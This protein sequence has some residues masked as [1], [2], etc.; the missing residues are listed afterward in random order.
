MTGF[1]RKFVDCYAKKAAPLTRYLKDDMAEPFDL[2]DEATAA[3]RALKMAI[4]SAP[5]LALPKA[6]G[7]FVLETDASA[8]QL[9][10]QLLQQQEDSSW[11]PIGFWS[12]Q[13][14]KAECNYSPTE[15][16]ALAIFWGIKMCRPY[17]ERTR[18]VVRSDHQALR[19]L[20]STST[21]D[22]NARILRWKLALSAYD[23]SV[24]YKPG[25]TN[26][27]ADELSRMVTD[28]LSPMLDPAEEDESIPC[29]VVDVEPGEV[30]LPPPPSVPLESPLL[31]VPKS[32]KA[33]SRNELYRAQRGDP[34]CQS[35]AASLTNEYSLLKPPGLF[36]DDDG[37]LCCS[38][39][40]PDM[41]Y[42]WVAP[43][44]L[45]E[46]ICKL[47]HFT[48]VAGHPGSTRMTANIA[49]TWYWPQLAKD[50]LAMVRRCPSCSAL[51]L[52]R[53]P[54]RTYPLTIFPPDRPLEFIAI[55]VLGPL[56]RTSRGNQYV[57][58]ICDRFS[59]MSIAVA[60][61]DQT[62]STVARALVD[63]WIA[64]FG[65]PITL[66]SDNGPCFASKFFQVLTKVLGVKHVFTSAYRPTTNGQVERW[67]ATLV[68]TLTNF[69]REKDWDLSLGLACVSYNSSVHAT[70]GYAPLE[71]STTREPAPS[72]WS[73]QPSLLPRGR[74]EKLQ[75][76]QALLA[77]AARLCES[78]K[79]T[80]HLRLERYKYLYDYH[81][82]RRHADLQVGDSVFVK[83]FMLEPGRSPKLSAPV[84]GPYPVVGIDGPNVV[85]RTRE[86]S[87]RLHLD[88]VMRC[89]TDLPSGVEWTPRKEVPTTSRRP[90]KD[91]DDE[92]VIDYLVSHA[93][94]EDEQRWLARVRWAGFSRDEDTWEPVTALPEHMV[95]R[96]ERRKKLQPGTL[97][98]RPGETPRL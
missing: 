94:T 26:K 16:E 42:R 65:I 35:L 21:S 51:R 28:G 89:P 54:K 79:E 15:R 84:S 9:G 93:P 77:R 11:R 92:Y 63:R 33:I 45:R 18:F 56:P 57:L 96:Y 70:T 61:P 2:D 7:T 1:Y 43:A 31:T 46:R 72:V 69:A 68:D 37:I 81:V 53:G 41:P 67:N 73:R 39:R 40:L 49:R 36:I 24:E 88:R 58:C 75:Y 29:L 6:T 95:A 60:M 80:T 32:M 48:K 64:V 90:I 50:C 97:R 17:L 8:C 86:G 14:N 78:A 71:L 23:F 76:R 85:I 74:D 47:H 12:R 20:F 10:V 52:K 4:I 30:D 13:C 55:D 83:T 98:R 38:P 66:L 25:P 5:I 27:V 82:R 3:H 87:E 34:W 91:P 62:A 44:P 19:W 22:G 59:K